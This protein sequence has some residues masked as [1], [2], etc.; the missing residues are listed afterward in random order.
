MKVLVTGGAGYIGSHLVRRLTEV[1]HLPVVLDSLRTGSAGAI[2][3]AELIVG[4]VRDVGALDA[5]LTANV[6]AVIHM[7]ALK[8]PAESLRDPG[9]YFDVNVAGTLAVLEAM[10][11]HGV[12]VFVYSSSCAVYGMP[13]RLPIDESAP[14]APTTPYGES[15]LLAER[16]LPWYPSIRSAALR[17]FN[18]AGAV[19]DGSLGEDWGA[20]I[21][22]IP[23]VLRAALGHAEQVEVYGTDYPTPDGT[24]V[25]DYV[26]VMDLAD[27]HVAAME[28]LNAGSGESI[29]L[30]LGTGVGASVA[31]VIRA[32]EEVTGRSVPTAIG[33][34]REGDPAAVWADP[35]MAHAVLGWRAR[36]D[37][38]TIISTAVRWHEL[39]PAGLAQ[40]G[41]IARR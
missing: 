11:R 7:A 24:A 30:N 32:V 33:P 12:G 28:R 14:L 17:Y 37:L 5:A 16:L 8:S 23:L 15:K 34:R 3:D 26:H 6:D 9:L 31:E 2:G 36:R 18:A 13:S 38:R 39:H 29:T 10:R 25:R 22:L 19:D 27:A 40:R 41:A 20:A 35:Q 21:N 1:G 4:D